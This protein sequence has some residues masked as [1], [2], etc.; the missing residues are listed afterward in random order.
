MI[1]R[2][3][4]VV[5]WI[6]VDLVARASCFFPSHFIGRHPSLASGDRNVIFD[7]YSLLPCNLSW[8]LSMLLSYMKSDWDIELSTFYS[9]Y[10]SQRC[11]TQPKSIRD[12]M[13]TSFML[14][15]SRNTFTFHDCHCYRSLPHT[16]QTLLVYSTLLVA[17]AAKT[18]WFAIPTR[19]QRLALEYEMSPPSEYWE[20]VEV[21]RGRHD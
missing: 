17:V 16:P 15:P 13:F 11:S 12:R 14:G 2:R 18:R 4:D 1:P 21:I 7:N 5:A 19:S 3:F 9:E 6:E 8:V 10:Y 20:L